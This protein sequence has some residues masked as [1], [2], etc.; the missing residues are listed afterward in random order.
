MS[1][2]LDYTWL[3]ILCRVQPINEYETRLQVALHTFVEFSQSMSTKPN[4]SIELIL[5]CC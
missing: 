3:Y 4:M 2:K 1:T 5:V